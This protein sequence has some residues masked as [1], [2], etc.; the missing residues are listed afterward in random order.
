MESNWKVQRR[1]HHFFW[2]NDIGFFFSS[3]KQFRLYS[4][5][6][7]LIISTLF[8]N[9]SPICSSVPMIKLELPSLCLRSKNS[10]FPPLIYL[11]IMTFQISFFFEKTFLLWR[12]G[13]NTTCPDTTAHHSHRHHLCPPASSPR[14]GRPSPHPTLRIVFTPDEEVGRG[15][16]KLDLSTVGDFAYTID[17]GEVGDFEW[18]NFNA[19]RAVVTIKGKQFHPGDAKGKMCNAATVLAE[20]IS[21]LPDDKKPETTEV[22]TFIYLLYTHIFNY[23][24]II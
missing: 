1:L 12:N 2:R 22:I 7:I 4:F 24:F 17:G 16:E 5:F 11:F 23:I 8:L 10:S 15:T 9:T 21:R 14:S 19:W 3:F 13:T 18:E 20:F 6:K